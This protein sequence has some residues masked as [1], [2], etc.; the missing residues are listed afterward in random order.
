MVR[1]AKRFCFVAASIGVAFIVF[2]LTT[3][4]AGTTGDIQ[5]YVRDGRGQPIAGVGVSVV[6]PSS[7]AATITT[8]DGFYSLNGLPLDTYSV[9]F[10]KNGYVTVIIFGI[11]TVQDQS[12]RVSAR[13]EAVKTLARVVVRSSTSLVQPTVTADTYVVNQSRLSD[14]NGTPQDINGFQAL[15]SL[16]GVIHDAT[17]LEQ[18]DSITIRASEVNEVGYQYDGI[19]STNPVNGLIYFLFSP[20][21]NGLHSV[22]VSTGGYDVS[23]GN[24]NAGVINEVIKRGAFPPGGQATIRVTDPIFGHEISFDYGGATTNNRFSYYFSAGS[25]RDASD[26]GDRHTFLPLQLG[27]FTFQSLNDDVL[28]LFYH[29][30]QGDRDELQFLTHITGYTATV[31]YLVD[32]A[33]APYP[34]NNGDVQHATDPFG[35]RNFSTYQSSYTTLYPGQVAYRQNIGASEPFTLNTVLN[36]LSF[37]RQLTPSS[38]LDLRLYTINTNHENRFAY[39]F[40]SFTDFFYDLQS[41]GTGA[42]FDYTRQINAKH[43]LSVG[44]EETFYKNELAGGTPS[45]EPF[46]EPLE[47][48]GCPQA[49]KALGK[50]AVG[51]C[52]IAPFNAGINAQLSLGLPR[53]PGHAPL[54]TYASDLAHANDPLHRW[55]VWVRD[56]YQPTQRLT[57]TMGLRWDKE[58]ISLPPN[59]AEEST[60]YYLDDSGNVVTLPGR[61]IGPDVTR[62]AQLSPRLAMGYQLGSRDVL[63]FSY[64]KNIE[65]APLQ[66]VENTYQIPSSLQNCNIASGCF[67]TLPGYGKTNHVTNLYQQILLDLNTNESAQ[68]SPALPETAVNLDFS[69]EHDFGGGLEL[70]VTPYYR[71]STNYVVGTRELLFT[72]PSGTPVFGPPK[73]ENA[74]INKNTGI[75]FAVQRN[76]EFGLSGLLDAT[77]D[78]TFANY[79]SDFGGPTVNTAALA[80]GH[81]YH[82]TYI[83]PVTGTFNLTY[84][85][86]SGLHASTTISYESGFR[87]G[88]GKK[89]FVLDRSGNPVQVLNTD[90]AVTPSQ[91][92]YFTDPTKPGTVFAPN[93][94]G[95][96]DTPEGDD[97]GTLFTPAIA[98]INVTLSH[99]LNR[100]SHGAQMGVR[101]QN[102]LG[103]YTPSF[104]PANLYYVPQGIGGYGPGSGHNVNQCS[105]GQ[106]FACEPFRYN[107][108]VYPYESEPSGLPRV[109]TFFL[110]AKY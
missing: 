108:S 80:A 60:S 101:I 71:K 93:I 64:G 96:R 32:P 85:T 24:T 69:Y 23:E 19:D 83:A 22:Q 68:Y 86:P 98:L 67:L 20:P 48:L 17:P 9:T 44:A 46:L 94:T 30:A 107:Q 2:G 14:I 37:K 39:N 10:S 104:I 76:A 1:G 21:L 47:A 88:V 56:R 75:E 52:Y 26:Y 89:T 62:P 13:L 109:Y 100:G 33:I 8:L 63:R 97:P 99:D 27:N 54:R 103:N 66:L 5:G 84:N 57:I 4:G 61:P 91:A 102:V 15:E 90:L 58:T 73:S 36:K 78:N 25:Q 11:T 3:A 92:Y 45:V 77:Y 28:N 55:D 59:A 81:L 74:G 82:V 7:H 42:A 53:D 16:P 18:N 6:S 51:G 31:D 12:V 105:P 70:R 110:S 43:A 38:F 65:F 72:L 106:I 79:N 40:G 35:L 50:A 34:S 87:Y 95:S 49:S 41:T 29:F